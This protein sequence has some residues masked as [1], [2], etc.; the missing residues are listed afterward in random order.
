MK[1]FLFIVAIFIFGVVAKMKAQLP[2]TVSWE[3]NIKMDKHLYP[4][5]IIAGASV[6]FKNQGDHYLGEPKGL[7]GIDISSTYRFAKFKLEIRADEIADPTVFEFTLPHDKRRE[8]FFVFPNINYR[9]QQLKNVK[10][11]GPLNVI[12]KLYIDGKEEGERTETVKL[13]SINDCPFMIQRADNSIIDMKWMFAAY[14]NEHHPMIDD[15]LREALNTGLVEQF[16]DYQM[17]TASSKDELYRQTIAVWTAL[18]NRKL[19]Y[20]NTVTPS[21]TPGSNITSQNIRL[22]DEA[23]KSAQ[24]NCVDGSTVFASIFGHI[25]IEPFL[26]L[27]PSHCYMGFYTSSRMDTSEYLC[28]ET[29]LIGNRKINESM[30]DSASLAYLMGLFSPEIAKANKN[31]IIA[32]LYALNVGTARY[33]ADL[34]NILANDVRYKKIDIAYSRK[35]FEVFPIAY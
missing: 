29:T 35:E 2:E 14:V 7:L 34:P 3:P 30:V 12:F 21:L 13:H 16:S 26:V 22:F 20:S 5:Y 17:V 18:Y 27:E 10:Q 25:G 9:F 15:I 31:A 19:T 32:Y 33:K 6:V 4:S 28:L 8:T 24:A 23:I 1:R 11:P